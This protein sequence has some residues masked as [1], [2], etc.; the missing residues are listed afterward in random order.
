MLNSKLL[1]N[2]IFVALL[3]F[4]IPGLGQ[5]VLGHEK[6][7]LY[8]LV[9]Y[10]FLW[11]GKTLFPNTFSIYFLFLISLTLL[12]IYAAYDTYKLAKKI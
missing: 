10:V 12:A 4:A 11:I 3:S 9:S 6:R 5:L 1:V 2:P 8:F 7:G